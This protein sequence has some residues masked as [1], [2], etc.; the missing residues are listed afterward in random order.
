MAIARVI[1]TEQLPEQSDKDAADAWE[2][3]YFT[4][5]LGRGMMPSYHRRINIHPM[6]VYAM[7][8]D[9]QEIRIFKTTDYIKRCEINLLSDSFPLLSDSFPL[10]NDS[11]PLLN[12][13]FPLLNDSFP[14]L[15]DSF[16]LLNDS[17]PLLNDSFPLS[18]IIN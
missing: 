18:T 8:I 12:D 11:F 6:D 3:P 7:T 16:P 4:C 10:L 9:L 13:S 2:Y 17:F 1:A 15:S 5:K 14:L